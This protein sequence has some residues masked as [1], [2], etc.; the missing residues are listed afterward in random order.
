MS[1][2]IFAQTV[3]VSDDFN[4]NIKNKVLWGPDG[5]YGKGVLTERNHRLEFTVSTPGGSGDY[6]YRDLIAS[7]GTYTAD[8]EVQIDAFNG[9]K[10]SG[11]KAS[12]VGMDIFRC[13]DLN[14]YMYA[15]WYAFGGAKSLFAE[16]GSPDDLVD[17]DT[18]D[19]SGNLPLAGSIRISFDSI[20]K[21]ITLYYDTGTGWVPFVSFGISDAGNGADGNTDWFMTD[22][23]QFCFDVYGWSN[24]M[25]IGSGKIY[26]D[27]FQATG[28]T[29][30]VATRVLQPDGLEPVQAGDLYP[31]SWEAPLVATKFKLQYS[32]DNG[33]TWKALHPGVDFVIG[34]NYNWQVP[35][36][37]NNKG[38]CLVKIAGYN[39]DGVKI[40]GDVSERFTIE[41]LKLDAPNGGPPDLTSG[42]QFLI[43]WTTNPN[44]TSVDHV[45]LSYTRDNGATWKVINTTADPSDDGS[46]L[47]T[48]PIVTR[49]KKNC[50]VK[51]VLKSASGKTL[52]SDVSDGVFK[53]LPALP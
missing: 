14:Y 3:T 8:W 4:D 32:L 30:P 29:A 6:T 26:A 40:G 25:T 19:L 35:L 38:K 37:T 17:V 34:R 27:N 47:W 50:K 21:I 13:D 7:Q 33:T 53:I 52:G 39:E 48:V 42:T 24:A 44:V 1:G 28:V 46:F 15:E 10:T 20:T 41:V 9:T 51:I 23:D 12:S 2:Q 49:E 11:S 5:G 22:G 43:T 16:L 18:G 36:T 45:Q 31:V